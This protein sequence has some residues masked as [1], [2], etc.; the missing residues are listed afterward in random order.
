[1]KSI[2]FIEWLES[3]SPLRLSTYRGQPTTEPK[4]SDIGATIIYKSMTLTTFSNRNDEDQYHQEIGVCRLDSVTVAWTSS[5]DKADPDSR[6]GSLEKRLYGDR[7]S[8]IESLVDLRNMTRP[9]IR[10]ISIQQVY[11]IQIP[12]PHRALG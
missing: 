4:R 9:Y 11:Q 7:T 1:M 5:V 12:T 8:V 6:H 2:S 3:L 10:S